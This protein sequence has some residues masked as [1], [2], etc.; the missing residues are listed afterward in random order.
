M[1]HFSITLDTLTPS[2]HWHNQVP[3]ELSCMHAVTVDIRR[4]HVLKVAQV[5]ATD[6][7]RL[8]LRTAAE[9]GCRKSDL[10]YATSILGGLHLLECVPSA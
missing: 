2:S 6:R 10:E 3:R 8:L 1:M 7:P 4:L 5:Q 9:G